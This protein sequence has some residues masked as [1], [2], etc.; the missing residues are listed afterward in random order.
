MKLSLKNRLLSSS[1]SFKKLLVLFVDFISISFSITFVLLIND[2]SFSSFTF[3]DKCRILA[4]PFFT[5]LAFWYSGVYSSVIRFIDTSLVLILFR[6]IFYSSA[7]VL[8]VNTLL[9]LL[10]SQLNTIFFRYLLDPKD[11]IVGLITFSLIVITSRLI[12]N[13]FLSER[14]S[15]KKLSSM[16][17]GRLVYNWQVL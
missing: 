5:V 1:R 3:F 2:Y 4:I 7:L 13:Y 14:K 8:L 17:L 11:W 16:G 9:I 12:A 15:E 6:A 10:W